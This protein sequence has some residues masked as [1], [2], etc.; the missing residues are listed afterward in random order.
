[1][2]SINLTN[3]EIE[4]IRLP[5]LNACKLFT[6]ELLFFENK[7]RWKKEKGNQE[8]KKKEE[9]RS[10]SEDDDQEEEDERGKGGQHKE[11]KERTGGSGGGGEE[12]VSET[13]KDLVET[14]RIQTKNSKKIKKRL[15]KK[16][17]D[18]SQKIESKKDL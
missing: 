3:I 5:K 10:S 14:S 11:R 1:M 18:R 17:N 12:G 2:S 7:P 13:G 15:L 4:G 6:P 9:K 8:I 16:K